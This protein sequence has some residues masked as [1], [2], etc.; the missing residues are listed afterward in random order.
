[1][2]GLNWTGCYVGGFIGG[3]GGSNVDAGEPISVAFGN[4]YNLT[5]TPYSYRTGLSVIGGGTLGCNWQASGSP[6][7][8]VLKWPTGYLDSS[9]RNGHR[10]KFCPCRK[11]YI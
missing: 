9:A 2:T 11:R 10:S 4:F 3:A 6:W 8:W 5:G 7:Y 1:M